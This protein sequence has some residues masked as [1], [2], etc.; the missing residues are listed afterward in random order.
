MK[1][2]IKIK[3]SEVAAAMQIFNFVL[4]FALMGILFIPIT[5]HYFLIEIILAAGIIP[6]SLRASNK[7]KELNAL[8]E[9]YKSMNLEANIE[10]I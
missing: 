3:R 2:Q 7:K 4:F 1:Y 5:S 6:L 8:I 10:N 9:K